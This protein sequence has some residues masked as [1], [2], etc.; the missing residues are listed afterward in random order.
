M[1]NYYKA[2]CVAILLAVIAG[3]ANT[4][5]NL[6]PAASAWKNA[7]PSV[8]VKSYKMAVSDQI[9]INVWKNP[10]LSLSEPIRPDGKISMPLIGDVRAVGLTPE[11]L[12]AKIEA[13]LASY[14]KAP[15]V[16]VILTSLQGHA[17]LSRIR[18]TGSVTQNISMPYHQGMTVLDA[19]LEAG[20][21][22]LYAD[23]NNTKLHRRTKKGSAAYDIRL[24]DI[25]EEGD[26]TTNVTLMPGD[27]ISVP[28]RSF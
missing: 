13:K 15:N 25:M 21:V 18:V 10:E 17:F 4:K 8:L 27:I 26:M 16:T 5:P 3:C 19:I 6:P 28:E 11:E 1:K 7:G 2:C 24:K 12:A 22:D 9:D 14:V 20:S 23:A